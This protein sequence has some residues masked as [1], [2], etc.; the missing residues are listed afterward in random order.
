MIRPPSDAIDADR[1]PPMASV[2]LVVVL[3]APGAVV[4]TQAGLSPLSVYR[5]VV[6]VVP[7]PS[8]VVWVARRPFASRVNVVDVVAARVLAQGGRVLALDA[9]ELPDGQ[10]TAVLR[11]V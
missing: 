2:N 9:A 4:S 10:T 3:P 1:S 5:R 6:V 11:W 7:V 8:T